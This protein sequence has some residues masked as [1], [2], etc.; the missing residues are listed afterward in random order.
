MPNVEC[1]VA[2]YIMLNIDYPIWVCKP[3]HRRGKQIQGRITFLPHFLSHCFGGHM[4]VNSYVYK[5]VEMCFM[6]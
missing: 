2:K 6:T 3:G 5:S 4:D 1:H